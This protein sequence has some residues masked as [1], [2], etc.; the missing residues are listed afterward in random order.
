MS[1]RNRKEPPLVAGGQGRDPD[2]LIT[3]ALWVAILG[4]ATV[5]LITFLAS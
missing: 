5:L 3:A 4:A 2:D 1:Y